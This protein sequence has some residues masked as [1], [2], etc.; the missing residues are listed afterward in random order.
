M[1]KSLQ[2]R[3]LLVG[4][5]ALQLDLISRD[6]LIQAM[7]AWILDKTSGIESLLVRQGALDEDRRQFLTGIAEKHLELHGNKADH[8]LAAL[9]SL[10]SVQN[11]LMDLQ[12]SQMTQTLNEASELR[13]DQHQNTLLADVSA[14][15][16]LDTASGEASRRFRILRP[17]AEGGLGVVS[18]AEDRELNRQVAFKQIK[19]RMAKDSISRSRFMVEAEVTGRLEH[20]GI[21]PVYSLGTDADGAPFYA[22]RFIQ[23]DSLKDEIRKFHRAD[24]PSLSAQQQALRLRSLIKRLVDVCDAIEYA[25]SR[26]VLHRDLKPGNIMLGKYGETLVVDWGLARVQGKDYDGQFD[27]ETLRP[28]SG[29]GSTETRM[30]TVIG[31]VAFMSPEQA[32]GALDEL[33]P[34]SDVYSLGATLY[35]IL[36]GGI[37]IKSDNPSDSLKKAREGNFPSAA[38]VSPKT[39]SALA[40]ICHKAMS[41]N[42][43]DRYESAAA[44]GQEL[45]LWLAGEPVAAY[46]EPLSKRIS[47]VVSRHQTAFAGLATFCVVALVALGV[48]QQVTSAKNAELTD[49]RNRQKDMIYSTLANVQTGLRSGDDLRLVADRIYEDSVQELRGLHQA[50]PQQAAV[51]QALADGLR[52]L[53]TKATQKGDAVAGLELMNEAV[54][55]QMELLKDPERAAAMTAEERRKTITR[56]VETQSEVV[57]V[58]RRANQ[59]ENTKTALAMSEQLLA[60]YSEEDFGSDLTVL[61]L[62]ARQLSDAAAVWIDFEDWDRVLKLAEESHQKHEQ[63]FQLTAERGQDFPIDPFNYRMVAIE[64]LGAAM[65]ELGRLDEAESTYQEG[66]RILEEV[67]SNEV[68]NVNVSYLM[69]RL[70]DS[71]SQLICL[72]GDVTADDI[73]RQQRAVDI[74]ERYLNLDPPQPGLIGYYGRFRCTLARLLAANHQI[75]EALVEFDAMDDIL[76]RAIDLSEASSFPIML[77]DALRYRIAFTDE[78]G[79]E[80]F[81]RDADMAEAMKAANTAVE[82]SNSCPAMVRVR[83]ELLALKP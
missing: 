12:D 69:G 66:L 65:R 3:N 40:A 2:D 56:L 54:D 45:D 22:M 44:L 79:S 39:D 57:G 33:G 49:S 8:S 35:S 53:A 62:T 77:A 19:D 31:T 59:F 48:L 25:H 68:K 30:G 60:E 61:R 81:D 7:Q 27:E 20:P 11:D 52:I 28:A 1:S 63:F 29:S 36:T 74:F 17:H 78:T 14:D 83:S 55:L 21:V 75:D 76:R 71:Y 26:G 15:F 46:R 16:S 70:S 51:Q 38:A 80:R 72:R 18:V 50:D 73:A 41:L 32:R 43:D 67:K 42:R 13:K 9:S 23:G 6:Q 47:R 24:Q 4:V 34:R 10:G 82:G 5:I 37:P 64:Q 58:L